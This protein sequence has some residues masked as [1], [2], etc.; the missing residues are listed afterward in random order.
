MIKAAMAGQKQAKI[1]RGARGV[2]ETLFEG[3]TRGRSG[4]CVCVF[5]FRTHLF[6]SKRFVLAAAISSRFLSETKGRDTRKKKLVKIDPSLPAQCDQVSIP[7]RAVNIVNIA[8]MSIS[9]WLG[10]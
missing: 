9:R 7:G 3:A 4:A 2:A 10:A 6:T 5:F 1:G 8:C